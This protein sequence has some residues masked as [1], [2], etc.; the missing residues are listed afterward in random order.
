[1]SSDRPQNNQTPPAEATVAFDGQIET[2]MPLQT[3]LD[4]SGDG[5]GAH[6]EDR[7][8]KKLRA[9]KRIASYEILD[10]IGRGG[11]GVVYKAQDLRLKRVVALKVILAGGHAGEVEL[12]RF[13][14][15][16]EAV[17]RLKH[18]NFV[19]IYEVG[20]DEGLPFLVLEYCPGGSLEDR[21]VQS[22]P[23]PREAAEL[24]A[25]LAEA[26]DHAH[27]AGVIHRDLKP[28][29]VLFDENGEPRITDF[30]LAKRVGEDDSHTKTVSV[31]GSL[32][33]MSPEQASGNTRDATPAVDI[34]ALGAILYRLL[35]GRIPFEGTST[36][37]SLQLVINGIPVP[38][39]RLKPSCPRDL[40]TICLKCLEKSPD[41]RYRTA[42]ELADDLRRFLRGEPITARSA[43]PLE[44]LVSWAR[45]NPLPTTLAIG[46]VAMLAILAGAMAWT[47]YRNY[48]IIETIQHQEMRIQELR[49]Q[50]LYL[51]E[52]L[53]NSCSLA[54]TTGE[55]RWEARYR[56]VL[57]ELDSAIKQALELVPAAQSEMSG[58]DAANAALVRLEEQ[59]FG[60]V[61][62]QQLTNAWELLNSDEYR[63]N[64]RDYAEGLAS[65]SSLLKTHS[66]AVIQQAHDEAMQFLIAAISMA[67][68]VVGI[69]I[70]GC[71]SM[72]R[73][74][75]RQP[76]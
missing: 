42:G 41:H 6:E 47:T 53:T 11:M 37:E 63:R 45:R 43:T 15:E 50:I 74:L 44:Q 28:G 4:A 5:V 36:A 38:V 75:R 3:I 22:P 25:K 35:T 62:Q 67:A 57:P 68:L 31:M 32:G 33:Y 7:S 64:K 39:R 20:S 14:I 55:P 13:Q 54:A 23:S 71:Y 30:G 19:Q 34:Y 66:E 27:G 48:E 2:A 56:Q 26:M 46:G 59:A 10:E 69:L 60:L 12:A 76:A 29:N 17:A 70:V 21:I 51:D 1:M 18:L 73:T 65:F 16:A 58:V 52:V 24:V 61:R 9:P 49:G 72:F 40:E 8:D